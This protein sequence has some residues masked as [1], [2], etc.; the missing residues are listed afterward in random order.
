MQEI[1]QERDAKI[2]DLAGMPTSSF[3]TMDTASDK[4]FSLVQQKLQGGTAKTAAGV[5]H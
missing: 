1:E 4:F 3:P 5:H 2:A